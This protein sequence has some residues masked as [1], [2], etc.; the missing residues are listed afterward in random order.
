MATEVWP[1]GRCPSPAGGRLDPWSEEIARRIR[2]G[3]TAAFDEFFDGCAGKL[4]AYLVGM[5]GDRATAEDLVQETMLRVYRH[6]GRYEERG[7]FRAWV[8]RIA[9]NLALTEM[10]RRR[11]RTP[12]CDP[13]ALEI[14]DGRSSDPAV[15]RETQDRE[16]RLHQ[17]LAALADDQRA[18][19]LL[20]V[21]EGMRI[22]EVARTLSVPEGTVKSRLHH[23]VRKLRELVHRPEGIEEAEERHEDLR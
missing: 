2:R 22:R 11:Y 21:R 20:R 10:R 12:A 19:I 16:R 7:S 4:L 13:T 18:V 15:V 8:F 6:I 5:V 14:P 23:A 17:A 1:I 9:T 3:D